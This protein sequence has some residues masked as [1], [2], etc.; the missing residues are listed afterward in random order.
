MDK[1]SLF[2]LALSYLGDRYYKEG[3][4]T[5]PACEAV[6]QHCVSLAF[7]YSSWTFATRRVTLDL[8][9][10]ECEL[11][12]DCLRLQKVKADGFSLAER[13]LKVEGNLKKVELV[14]TTN[15][16][17]QNVSTPEGQPTF[18]EAVA[19]LIASK[20]APRLTSDWRLAQTLEQR[21]YQKLGEAKYKDAVQV[22]SNDQKPDNHLPLLD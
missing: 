18:D 14:Y 22:D 12:A 15:R 3:S 19:L 20:L 6:G 17:V 2:N 8:A 16:Y 9:G 1:G 7:D 5:A 4:N 21:A 13:V 11:P 10:G